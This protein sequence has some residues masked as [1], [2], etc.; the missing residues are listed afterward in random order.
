[1]TNKDE[2]MDKLLDRIYFPIISILGLIVEEKDKLSPEIITKLNSIV[3]KTLENWKTL[4][5]EP[6]TPEKEE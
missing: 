1:M 3:D 2:D 6:E 5:T 4:N